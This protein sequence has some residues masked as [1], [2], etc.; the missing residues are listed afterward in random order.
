MFGY[1]YVYIFHLL[2]FS[3]TGGSSLFLVVEGYVGVGEDIVRERFGNFSWRGSCLDRCGVL[4]SF[5]YV[6]FVIEEGR[7]NR[8]G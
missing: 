6:G 1:A 7:G 5:S 3:V 2:F 4:G 8:V